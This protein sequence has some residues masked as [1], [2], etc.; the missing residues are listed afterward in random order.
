[1]NSTIGHIAQLALHHGECLI[2]IKKKLIRWTLKGENKWRN[3]T[4]SLLCLNSLIISQI[5]LQFIH[6]WKITD[7]DQ[8]ETEGSGRSEQTWEPYIMSRRN[9]LP[10][11]CIIFLIC[12]RYLLSWRLLNHSYLGF[13]QLGLAAGWVS[14]LWFIE[15]ELRHKSGRDVHPPASP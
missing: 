4:L 3:S 8:Q 14:T 5:S 15:R 2:E 6:K 1:M 10:R 7:T 9:F 13:N 12:M 11:N